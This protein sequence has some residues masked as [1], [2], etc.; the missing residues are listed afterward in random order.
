MDTYL[1]MVVV[2]FA[3]A[4]ADLIIGVSNDAVNFLNSAIGSKVAT[5]KTI[6]IVAA[7]GIV[8]GATFSSGMMEV[9][10]KGI[11]NPQHF[12]FSEI[13]LIFLAVMIT[14]IILLDTFNTLGMPTSTTVSIVFE[15][16][17]ASVSIAMFKILADGGD[18][19]TY[20]NSA[21]ALKIISGILLS[22]IVS[23]V[24]GAIA[25]YFS[26][27]A[28]SFN[29]ERRI[30]YLSAIWGGIAITA[31]TYFIVIKGLKGSTFAYYP[32]TL[33]LEAGA[34]PVILKQWV[35]DMVMPI[36][37]LSFVGWTIILQLLYIVFKLDILKLTVLVGTFALAMAF[38][39]NDLVNFIGVPLAG[40]AAYTDFL[41]HPGMDPGNL[42]MESL[43]G[44]SVA[45]ASFLI[46]AG[47]IMVVT[48]WTSKKARN[49]IKT[50]LDLSRQD[51][52]DE[53][54][55][56]SPI[57]R[58]MVRASISGSE[59]L[60][61]FVPTI[62][63]N[64]LSR[65][66]DQTESR[67]KYEAMGS[68]APAF[69]MVR[70][71]VNLVMASIIISMATSQK[72]PLST[73]YVTFMVA[74]GTSLA[75]KAWGRES[76]VFRITGVLSVILGWFFTALIAFTAAFVVAAILH[77]LGIFGVAL[78]VAVAIFV[79]YKTQILQK[80][81]MAE[82]DNVDDK[83]ASIEEVGVVISMNESV[84]D[85]LAK[86]KSEM[87]NVLAALNNEDRR[88]LKHANESIMI[89]NK[90]AKALK[91]GMH[92]T[93]SKLRMETEDSGLYYVQV[94]DYLR[95]MAHSL[96]FISQP[97]YEHV[98]NNHKKMTDEQ[99]NDLNELNTKMRL[100]IDRVT[101]AISNNNFDELDAIIA[102]QQESVDFIK[103]I[104]KRQVKRIKKGNASTKASLLYF[105]I[106]HEYHNI[107]LQMVN[108]L[109]SQRDFITK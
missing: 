24:F 89:I 20:I 25:M 75:D 60:S 69:D 55:G 82:G 72:L 74:M 104:R 108:L 5:F 41:A 32:M 14:D 23:F 58:S 70:A 88:S 97:A 103:D 87:S 48:L 80:K 100:L 15:L 47:L 63:K 98:L 92:S 66:F 96:E 27:L 91:K 13:M 101:F 90:D 50:S 77:Y 83:R 107:L 61:K 49:V 8:I 93:I 1:I 84:V 94:L 85:S 59:T 73:T 9:A 22:V 19:A 29:Y 2:L 40:Y 95:E 51:E 44:K 37:G 12:F 79:L 31:I 39:G 64:A 6:M 18:M 76:A 38:A 11:M 17:G 62:V 21:T 102:E 99:K 46:M 28:F 36:V 3:L 57:A 42:L 71:S 109:K 68:E 43:T 86:M 65:Q 105:T 45:P 7:L 10:R 54:F 78:M 106:V 26:R 16:L 33:G 53:K 34:D 30:K 52:G 81:N 4:I 35:Q 67:E 56:A